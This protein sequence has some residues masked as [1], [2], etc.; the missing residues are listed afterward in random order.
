[1]VLT[2]ATL[3][4]LLGYYTLPSG[5]LPDGLS[6]RALLAV[7]F[8]G[9]SALLVAT[10]VIL[11]RRADRR[12]R[13][14]VGD[15]FMTLV[16]IQ[17]VTDPALSFLPLEDLL[18]LVLARTREAVGG[19][20]AS[21]LLLSGDERVLEV[22][23]SQG[24][25]ELSPVGTQVMVGEGLLGVVAEWAR[26][27]VTDEPPPDQPWGSAMSSRGLGSI[28]AAPLKVHDRVIGL[29]VAG[30]RRPHSFS[31]GDLRILEVVADRCAA[32]IE[33]AR[34]DEAERRSRLGAEHARMHLS[35]LARGGSAL[36]RA[37]ESY[38]DALVE[39]GQ[40]VVPDF[41]DWFCADVIDDT[42]ELRRVT[43]RSRGGAVPAD[44][45]TGSIP[46]RH[47]DG[48]RLVRLAVAERRPQVLA[49][50]GHARFAA[51]GAAVHAAYDVSGQSAGGIESMMVVPV[52]A[53]GVTSGALSFTTSS[54]RR[55]FRRS[56]LE[57]ALGLAERV[58]VAVERVASWKARSAAEHLAVRHAERLQRL[59][60]AALSVNA[61][62]AAEDVLKLLV[63]HAYAVLACDL[64]VVAEVP[65]SETDPTAILMTSPAV[66]VEGDS[67]AA[68][69]SSA[70]DDVRR[71]GGACRRP[72]PDDVAGIVGE[73]AAVQD[74]ERER[75]SPRLNSLLA[76]PLAGADGHFAR[77][78]VALGAAWP[79]FTDE[80]ESVLTLLS[81]MAS[82]ALQNAQLY[83]A[84]VNNEQRL[85]AVVESSPLAI[86]ELDLAGEARWW[87]R[88][89]AELFGWTEGDDGP[90]RVPGSEESE[91]VLAG[92]WER[93]RGGRTT[94]GV[95]M[96]SV[97]RR[98]T[99]VSLSVSSAPLSQQG[100]T[101]GM[102]LVA[103]DVT[104]RQ[105][106]LEQINRAE[107]LG[108]LT[109]MAGALAHD[110]NNLLTV[111]LGCSDVLLRRAG[112][113]PAIAEEVAAIKRAGQRAAELTS[114]L[115]GI[116]AQ[117]PLRSETLD[118]DEVV[119][120]LESMIA[121]LLG[122]KI[123]LQ[124]VRHASSARITA[125]RGEL[126]RSLLNLAVNARDAMPD[127]GRLVVRT[128]HVRERERELVRISVSDTGVGMDAETAAHC[129]EPFFTTK[130]RA[131][132]SGL[133]LAT[134]QATVTRA[135]GEV[136]VKSAPGS[137]AKFTMT[138]P[139]V[140]LAT[141]QD[142]VATGGAA[143]GAPLR[144]AKSQTPRHPVLLL[145][146]DE[147]ELLRL[148]ARELEADG[149]VV[150]A[151]GNGSQAL[152]SLHARHG[153]V[154]LLVTDVVM[155]GMSGIELADAVAR[156]Y[157]EIPV[158]FVSGHLDEDITGRKA[159]PRGAS[160]LAKP[161]TP[162]ELSDRVRQTL[163]ERPTLA[164]AR[165]SSH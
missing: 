40:I 76:V 159:L 34:L 19:D 77:V 103:D 143:K 134:V 8:A 53:R 93:A 107:R 71:S 98:G 129:F 117:R 21:V 121:G 90:N 106:L 99:K 127:G 163:E 104:E 118:V 9:L 35:V 108:A 114:Q 31:V 48:D 68:I 102:L 141:E 78:I 101:V 22:R 96:T 49:V 46:H 89:A 85:E 50:G 2:W 149:F 51:R 138:F 28:V 12:L 131:R 142:E 64:V 5:D 72:G 45:A 87:N 70:C 92:M 161:Y 112:D 155:P 113:Q 33:R 57:T 80:D 58:E 128:G 109:R 119:T 84:V 111:I 54:R 158:L 16:S 17:A 95:P 115:T 144:E 25:T 82:V 75:I 157:P 4:S 123:R 43:A 73:T 30:A 38:D 88:A 130:G 81:G 61:P 165:A 145:V 156:R 42:G 37:L 152:S 135:G 60:E 29:V 67:L 32:D 160:L 150:V 122:D 153:A 18:Q 52:V 110:F 10:I 74:G 125:D 151:V 140:R 133:G 69:V 162:S 137:G 11:R 148:S 23:S 7:V 136:V 15:A 24:E 116:G 126:E 63:E 124:V 6:P 1:M 105:R 62:L 164:G 132:G 83:Q 55:A 36:A 13:E 65:E 146:D 79:G 39:L 120:S 91:L 14:A 41:C 147:P 3:A 97:G 56:D 59:L 66:A 20:V 100:Q 27:A 26:P 154:D 47:P 139:A 86:A 94:I 44:L